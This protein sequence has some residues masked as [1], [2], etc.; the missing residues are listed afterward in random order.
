M[1]K[2]VK[3]FTIVI[4]YAVSIISFAQAYNSWLVGRELSFYI[5]F[6]GGVMLVIL[7]TVALVNYSRCKRERRNDLIS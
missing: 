4:G 5:Y 3:P 1:F 7:H 2:N 6:F